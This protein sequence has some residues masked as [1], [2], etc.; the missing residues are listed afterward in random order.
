[1]DGHERETAL[2]EAVDEAFSRLR[3]SQQQLLL[4]HRLDGLPYCE[5]A[6][7]LGITEEKVVRRMAEMILALDKQVERVEARRAQTPYPKISAPSLRI[8]LIRRVTNVVTFL[9]TSR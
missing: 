2:R 9:F 6:S 4:W 3:P 8:S 1:M 5:I 7:R